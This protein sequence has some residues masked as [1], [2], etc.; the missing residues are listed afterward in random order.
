LEEKCRFGRVRK[1]DPIAI[2]R[3]SSPRQFV[4]AVLKRM[5]RETQAQAAC[6]YCAGYDVDEKCKLDDDLGA[7][8]NRYYL[9]KYRLSSGI[10]DAK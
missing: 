9:T 10:E 5:A 4:P 3:G 2:K 7:K 1:Q 8:S 6:A